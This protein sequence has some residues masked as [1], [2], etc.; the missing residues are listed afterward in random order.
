[1]V[2]V[3]TLPAVLA[4]LVILPVSLAGQWSYEERKDAMTDKVSWHIYTF[5]TPFEDR[6]TTLDW[7]CD[8]SGLDVYLGLGEYLSGDAADVQYRFDSANASPP[9]RWQLSRSLVVAPKDLVPTITASARTAAK[10]LVRVTASG[11]ETLTYTFDLDG[12]LKAA[13]DA[14]YRAHEERM[15]RKPM[16]FG[17]TNSLTFTAAY[18][19]LP[20]KK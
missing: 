3:K 10:L 5:A 11:G 18:D 17:E 9:Q 2:R 12:S 8:S 13:Q 20:C 4:T 1:M 16:K 15:G 14:K 6:F 7:W 19:R